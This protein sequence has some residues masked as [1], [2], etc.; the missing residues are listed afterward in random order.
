M[1]GTTLNTKFTLGDEV[2]H[3]EWDG[4]RFQE[5]K[6]YAVGPYTIA[7]IEAEVHHGFRGKGTRTHVSYGGSRPYGNND[8]HSHYETSMAEK[9]CF[10][11]EAE[12]TRVAKKR[13]NARCEAQKI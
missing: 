12:A 1:S 9:D 11:T 10:R 3:I 2:F 7:K 13:W 5:P 8:E 6:P 4:D